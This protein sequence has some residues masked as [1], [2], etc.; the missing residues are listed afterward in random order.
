MTR[1]LFFVALPCAFF[2][3]QQFF[4]EKEDSAK[5]LFSSYKIQ[6]IAIP[7]LAITS[8]GQIMIVLF[9]RYIVEDRERNDFFQ[10]P[11]KLKVD[12]QP[13]INPYRDSLIYEDDLRRSF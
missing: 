9:L 4:F 10:S 13:N 11:D 6:Y 3:I 1:P 2:P 7:L 8:L 12:D 5:E